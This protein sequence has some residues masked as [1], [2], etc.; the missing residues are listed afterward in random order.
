M[1]T[2][3]KYGIVIAF[4][5]FSF[6]VIAQHHPPRCG[7]WRWNIKTLTDQQGS[8]LVTKIPVKSSIDE[9]V[10]EKPKN[11]LSST[12]HSDGQEPRTW[13]ENQVVEIIAIVEKVKHESDDSDFHLVLASPVSGT[14]MVGEIP[15]PACS[16]F[17]NFPQL[18]ELFSKTRQQGMKIWKKIKKTGTPQRVRI[19]GVPFWDGVHPGNNP[20]GASKYCREIHPILSIESSEVAK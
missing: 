4:L 9:L 11:F 19:T 15:D 12:S 18:R 1:K 7:K 6:I 3:W 13:G 5:V 14:T 2:F 8:G 10:N 16:T 20:T 17:D